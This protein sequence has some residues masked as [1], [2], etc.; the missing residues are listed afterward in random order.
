MRTVNLPQRRLTSPRLTMA[1]AVATVSTLS[2]LV[3]STTPHLLGA[4]LAHA[5][6]GLGAARPLWLWLAAAAFLGSLVGTAAAWRTTLEACGTYLSVADAGAR[7]GIGSLVNT[8]TPY[9]L[10]DAVRVGLFARTLEG[11]QRAWTA[12][13]AFGAIEAARVL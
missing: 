13:G 5:Y 7:Y 4:R 3:V 11:P 2:V 1:I 10:G 9:R 6:D 12:G 8:V